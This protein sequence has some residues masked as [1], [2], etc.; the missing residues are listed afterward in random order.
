MNVKSG[1]ILLIAGC[2]RNV[3]KTTFTCEI[4]RANKN[5][6]PVAVKITSHLHIQTPGLKEIEKGTD[7]VISEETN[8]STQK[9]SSLFLQNGAAK[10]YLL[11]SEKASLKTAFGKLINLLSEK[12]PVVIESAALIDI[13]Q[14]EIFAIILPEGECQKEKNKALLNRADLIIV[15]DGKQFHPPSGK[16]VFN[17]KW[18]LK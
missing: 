3:G 6:K 4:I 7:W 2:G 1:N 9:D 18:M 10:S 15:S 14:P 11:Q 12:Q 8:F 13:I 17:K 5:I 16:I